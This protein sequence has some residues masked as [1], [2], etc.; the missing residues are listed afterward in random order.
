MIYIDPITFYQLKLIL[1]YCFT[2]YKKLINKYR[3][4]ND[5]LLN[6]YYISKYDKI[7]DLYILDYIF[8]IRIST[9]INSQKDLI[10]IYV[11]KNNTKI[12]ELILK[13]NKIINNNNHKIL[14]SFHYLDNYLFYNILE[15]Y[16]CG[17]INHSNLLINNF[18]NYKGIKRN[19]I[20]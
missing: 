8:N 18:Y 7:H 15:V 5:I 2:T 19:E 20:N 14:L 13:N 16:N 11:Y 12:S 17:I 3:L 4:N 9:I 10:Y 1:F 6:S